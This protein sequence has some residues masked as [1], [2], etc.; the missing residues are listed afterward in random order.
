MYKIVDFYGKSLQQLKIKVATPPL[1]SSGLITSFSFKPASPFGEKFRKV[2]QRVHETKLHWISDL[3]TKYHLTYYI[4]EG[5]ETEID[6][7]INVTQLLLV[8]FF[9]YSL[10]CGVL[11]CGASRLHRARRRIAQRERLSYPLLPS[12]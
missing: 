7:E 11:S 12:D 5:S 1:L 6:D 9:G 2:L 10:S 4:N 8:L 3:K